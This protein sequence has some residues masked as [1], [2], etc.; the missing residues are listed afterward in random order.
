[1]VAVVQ[2]RHT[3]APLALCLLGLL[4]THVTRPPEASVILGPPMITYYPL[5][6]CCA[7]EPAGNEPILVAGGAP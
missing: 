4:V 1:M 3:L 7:A 5:M 2:F 6:C